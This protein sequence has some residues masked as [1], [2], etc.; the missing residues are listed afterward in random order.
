MPAAAALALLGERGVEAR[1]IDADAVLG[2][3][4]DGQ[5]DREAVRVVEPEGDVAGQP[6]RVGR[7]VLLAPA[8]DPLRAGQRD[9]RLL[10]LDRA[11][12]EG[13]RELGLLAGDG[14]RGSARGARPGAGRP[15]PSCR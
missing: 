15:R 14:R 4:L 1:A 9:E 10:E 13:P 11:G 2:G 3:Q 6:R 7:Q 5:V 12:V 8:D